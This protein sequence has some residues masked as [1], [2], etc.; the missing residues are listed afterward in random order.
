M[1]S[2]KRILFLQ[3]SDF[4]QQE[5]KKLFK[6]SDELVIF[7][8]AN[9]D[10]LPIDKVIE[11]QQY[12]QNIHWVNI[13]GENKQEMQSSMAFEIGQ[14]HRTESN[15][16]QFAIYLEEDSL[17]HIIAFLN[18]DGRTCIRV[19]NDTEKIDQT[20]DLFINL[21]SPKNE[22]NET[23]SVIKEE[24]PIMR[25]E[26]ILSGSEGIILEKIIETRTDLV[27]NLARKT[28]DRL[29]ESGNRPAQ[30]STLKSYILLNNQ[31]E[32]IHNRIDDIILHLNSFEEIEII[33]DNIIYNLD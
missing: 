24:M 29:I 33:E 13:L 32:N 1:Q 23:P 7:L 18:E 16:T 6:I 26:E 5:I 27:H 20:P 17:D 8:N 10:S 11:T 12:C 2:N 9:Q 31:E 3:Y 28:L 25:S 4:E 21:S 30:V 15:N 22:L 19:K 14:K